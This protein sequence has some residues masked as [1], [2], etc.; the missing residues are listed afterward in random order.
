MDLISGEI[1]FWVK[2]LL[3]DPI[4]FLVNLLPNLGIK[5]Y[6]DFVNTSDVLQDPMEKLRSDINLTPYL[7]KLLKKICRSY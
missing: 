2:K 7:L 5:T 1:K 4:I 3:I 6:Y